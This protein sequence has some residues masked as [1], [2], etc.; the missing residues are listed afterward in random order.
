M[1]KL[2]A[3]PAARELLSGM[4]CI[5]QR[6]Y[7]HAPSVRRHLLPG[8][9]GQTFYTGG[10]WFLTPNLE[11]KGE[12]VQQKYDDFPANDIRHGGKFDGAMFEAVVSF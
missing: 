8:P 11:A 1:F 12:Y 10:G 2:V 3:R 5:A 4:D 7:T 9:D 6:A